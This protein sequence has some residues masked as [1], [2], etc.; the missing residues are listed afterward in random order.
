MK[1]SKISITLLV[2]L[3][4]FG[5]FNTVSA[6]ESTLGT[7]YAITLNL[8]GTTIPHGEPLTITATTLDPQVTLVSLSWE[9]P[10]GEFIEEISVPLFSNGT[11]GVWNDGTSA[12]I[13]YASVTFIPDIHGEWKIYAVFR[14]AQGSNNPSEFSLPVTVDIFQRTTVFAVPELPLGTIGSITAMAIAMVTFMIIKRKQ[15]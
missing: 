8:D 14:D 3:L 12:E 11:Y 2:F 10:D 4:A 9:N 1:I 5:L 13:R 15:K 6:S 7:G